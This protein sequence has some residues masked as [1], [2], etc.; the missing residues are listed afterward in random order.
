MFYGYVYLITNKLN[1]KKYVGMRASRKFDET[2]WGS[3]ILI[4]RAV[5]KYGKE[6]FT[7]EVLHWCK[8]HDELI[9]TEV[10]EL[11]SRNA[12]I[13]DEYYNL[14]DT[15]T[16][17]LFGKDNGFYGKQHTEE[18]KKIISEKNTGT[19]WSDARRTRYEQWS[20]SEDCIA[21]R[22][23][24]SDIKKEIPISEQHRLAI[25]NSFTEERRELLSQ[26]KKEFYASEDGIVVR[27]LLSDLAHQRFSGVKKQMIIS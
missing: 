18:T 6:N 24:L 15:A 10:A 21:M 19:S 7:R 14:I 20:K 23:H 22:L 4:Q 16:P 26:Q 9:I 5:E 27:K 1:G 2:Y 12:A 17:I 8:N 11:Q 3:G 25:I 13:S